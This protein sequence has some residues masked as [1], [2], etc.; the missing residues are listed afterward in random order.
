MSEPFTHDILLIVTAMVA[1][2]GLVAV[3]LVKKWLGKIEDLQ[4]A[5]VKT[6]ATIIAYGPHPMGMV[7]EFLAKGMGRE[8]LQG[9]SFSYED[10]TKT[11]DLVT[12]IYDSNNP[13]L[14]MPEGCVPRSARQRR[15]VYYIILG[16]FLMMPPLIYFLLSMFL[17]GGK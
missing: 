3:I 16:E 7:Y 2:A 8:K 10:E 4:S 1:F 12:I 5:G 14:N 9:R 11:G 6:E 17:T 13:K 15:V